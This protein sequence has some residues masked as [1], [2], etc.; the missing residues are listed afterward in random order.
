MTVSSFSFIIIVFVSQSVNRRCRPSERAVSNWVRNCYTKTK[1]SNSYFK[2]LE[3]EKITWYR[4]TI[5]CLFFK[6][7]RIHSIEYHVASQINGQALRPASAIIIQP[8][9]VKISVGIRRRS[10]NS[11]N[12]I[13]LYKNSAS[14]VICVDWRRFSRPVAEP[15]VSNDWLLND[16]ELS[17]NAFEILSIGIGW[18]EKAKSTIQISV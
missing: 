1:R 16:N 13:W 6:N 11:F 9:S 18:I 3:E 8:F 10:W 17:K 4:T 15:V 12:S 7:N 5:N 2:C 14:V